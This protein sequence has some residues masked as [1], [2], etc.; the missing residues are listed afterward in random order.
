MSTVTMVAG[1]EA[2]N[3]ASS[4]PPSMPGIRM[5]ARTRSTGFAVDEWPAPGGHR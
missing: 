2:G 1:T 4:V 5:S 3:R